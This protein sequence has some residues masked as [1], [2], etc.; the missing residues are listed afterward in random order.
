MQPQLDD[1]T[2]DMGPTLGS[3]FTSR[4]R[5]LTFNR[6]SGSSWFVQRDVMMKNIEVNQESTLWV[7]IEGESITDRRALLDSLPWRVPIPA[8]VL[9]AVVRP[10]ES[11]VVEL[12]PTLAH[13]A[14]GVLTCAINPLYRDNDIDADSATDEYGFRG[15][16]GF[17]AARGF[18]WCSV[19]ATEGLIV[20]VH[21]RPFLGLEEVVRALEMRVNLAETPN[22][23][24]LLSPSIVLAT[25]VAYTS[26]MMLPDPTALLSEVDCIDEMVLLI[27]PG[28]R[29]QPDL[30]RR[31]ALLR[32]RIS[33]FRAVLYLKEKLFRELVTPSM[34]GSFVSCDTHQVIPIYKEALDK[35]TQ[36]ADRLDDARDILNQANLNFVTGVSMRMS[37]SSAN[38]DFKM[39]ILGQVATI[40][41]PLNLVA[42]IFGMNCEVPWQSDTHDNLNA[43]WGILGVMIAWVII[44][45]IPTIR[46]LL[47]GNAAKAI[48]P[49]DN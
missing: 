10:T 1:A 32:R 19:L 28:E 45:S 15:V 18:V 42:S 37:Q 41:L 30:L 24:E 46:E 5:F 16:D 17:D 31:V 23:Y 14:Y 7:D 29:D 26:E 4:K 9:D 11:D 13:Y 35:N 25:L 12:Q 40:C 21:D 39:Q 43:F 38:M 47:R 48:V 44:C 36:V 8:A 2:S 3:P 20:T 27:A 33:S 6:N 49:T 22:G 34:R